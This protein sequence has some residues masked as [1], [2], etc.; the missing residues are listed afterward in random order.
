M[1]SVENADGVGQQ[2][3]RSAGGVVFAGGVTQ[4]GP[5]AGSRIMVCRVQRKRPGTKSGVEVRGV[6][7]KIEY[8]PTAVLPEPVVRFLRAFCPSAVL[9]PG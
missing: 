3:E 4:K 8:Q 6:A 2:R 9:N 1:G 7:A 5:G